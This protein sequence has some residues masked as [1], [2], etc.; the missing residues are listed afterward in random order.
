MTD[1]DEGKKFLRIVENTNGRA[2]ALSGAWVTFNGMKIV[3]A[4]EVDEGD[5]VQRGEENRWATV[6]NTDADGV[7]TYN[8]TAVEKLSNAHH[9]WIW[10]RLEDIES[11]KSTCGALH[12]DDLLR[13]AAEDGTNY[14]LVPAWVTYNGGRYVLLQDVAEEDGRLCDGCC[15]AL[16]KGE[17]GDATYKVLEYS[18]G[19]RDRIFFRL[20]SIVNGTAESGPHE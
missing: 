12:E 7:V 11:G 2:Y 17:A 4:F 14:A 18:S 16:Q 13:V 20:T 6:E 19:L 8:D 10:R 9:D 15:A 5:T 1:T 3:L